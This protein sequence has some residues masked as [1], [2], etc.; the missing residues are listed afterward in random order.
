MAYADLLLLDVGPGG[1]VIVQAVGVHYIYLSDEFFLHVIHDIVVEFG[2]G[3]VLVSMGNLY[4][5][6]TRSSLIG[7][8]V[9]GKL[10]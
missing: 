4:F 5:G 3:S 6:N 9:A 10:L 2:I 1:V 8:C 7:E